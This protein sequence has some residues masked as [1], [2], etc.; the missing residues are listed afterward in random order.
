[1]LPSIL[2]STNRSEM[3]TKH[4]ILPCL[5]A[6]AFSACD[7]DISGIGQGISD[8][9][10]VI[11][12]DSNAYNLKGHTVD[13]V[14]IQSRTNDKLL[15]S[16]SAEPY[17]KLS[18]SFVSQLLSATSLNIPDSIPTED[19]H[20]FKMLARVPRASITGDSLAPQQ[21]S[22]YRLSA[23]LTSP[24]P[25]NFPTG[26]YESAPMGVSNYTLSGLTLGD[27]AFVKQKSLNVSVALD[28]ATGRNYVAQY[29]HDPSIFQWPSTFAKEFPG[30]YVKST[31]GKG[32]V[33]NITSADFYVYW[34]R[35]V[36]E[37][38]TE[39]DV[40]KYRYKNV[41]D[42]AC[43]FTTNPIVMSENLISY[44]PSPSLIALKDEGKTLITSPAGYNVSITFPGEQLLKDFHSSDLA[45]GVINS[46]KL[47]IPAETISNQYGIGAA[48]S[49]LMIKADEVDT[50][51]SEGKVPDNATSFIADYDSKTGQ[52]E[53]KNMREYIVALNDKENAGEP[54]DEDFLLIPV[55]PTY[56]TVKDNYTGVTTIYTTACVPYTVRP[57]M[58]L[59]DTSKA[60]ILFTYTNQSL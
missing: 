8:S 53:F 29:R 6:L 59:L 23:P 35:K 46:L 38:Y 7:D 18:C 1:M 30:I 44:T 4:L 3:K 13:A 43:L 41:T 60:V 19:I 15:G 57:T 16:I 33:A 51:F 56:E 12:V 20:S 25:D 11:S 36:L 10:V 14:A 54:L 47:T 24:L 5:A 9:K 2:N 27:S 49:L 22:V 45:M 55:L 34:D 40:V 17:G 28:A 26:C 50:F 37:A 21:L 39:D 32:C 48:P 52:Y 58:T 42:S 31:F